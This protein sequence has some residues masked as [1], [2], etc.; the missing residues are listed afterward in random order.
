MKIKA[1]ILALIAAFLVAF[2][3]APAQA[4][5]DPYT[6]VSN[7]ST[8]NGRVR[9]YNDGYYRD[10]W[11]K[12]VSYNYTHFMDDVDYFWVPEG[13]DAYS[14]WGYQYVGNRTYGPLP[15]YTYLKLQVVC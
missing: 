15:A 3:P 2:A 5:S 9:I 14:Q 12:Q 13:C 10:L 11:T 7:I 6:W 8:S 4:L 1:M